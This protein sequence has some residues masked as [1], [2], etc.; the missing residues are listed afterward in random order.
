MSAAALWAASTLALSST[1]GNAADDLRARFVGRRFRARRLI[2][3]RRD[4]AVR[5]QAARRAARR[6]RFELRDLRVGLGQAPE[7]DEAVGRR[8]DLR[9]A[10]LEVARAEHQRAH[11]STAIIATASTTPT[12]NL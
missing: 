8:R 5:F 9:H 11:A 10:E 1:C 6:L 3:E 2:V 4:A 12:A 7:R